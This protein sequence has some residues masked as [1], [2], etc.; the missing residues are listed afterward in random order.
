M[1]NGRSDALSPCSRPRLHGEGVFYYAGAATAAGQSYT[2]ALL[3]SRDGS[4][5]DESEMGRVEEAFDTCGIKLWE[6]Y[7]VRRHA[8]AGISASIV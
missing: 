8:L 1:W 2:G 4:W 3:V 5:P 7:E 6:L